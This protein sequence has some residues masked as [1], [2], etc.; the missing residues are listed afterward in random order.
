L[1]FSRAPRRNLRRL[2]P[3]TQR[4]IIDLLERRVVLPAGEPRVFGGPLRGDKG[5]FWRY[6]VGDWRIFCRIDDRSRTVIVVAIR[7]RSEAYR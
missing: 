6:R 2:D 1:S 7:H 4:R 3:P 5:E